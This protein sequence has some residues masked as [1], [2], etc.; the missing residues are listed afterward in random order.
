MQKGTDEDNESNFILDPSVLTFQDMEVR[1]K[2]CASKNRC[3]L[4]L[5]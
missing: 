1:S 5:L 4:H 3:E 2:C